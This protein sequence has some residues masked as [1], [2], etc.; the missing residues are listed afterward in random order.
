MLTQS[1]QLFEE[2]CRQHG[3]RY[4]RLPPANHRTPDYV[5]YV[6]RRKIVVEVKEISPNSNE[7]RAHELA[8]QGQ[9]VI[10]SSTPGERVRGKISDAIPQLKSATKGRFPGLLVLLDTGFAADH[11]NSY[12]IM[13]A[14]HGLET[15]YLSVPHAIAEPI[16]LLDKGFGPRRKTT[17]TSN[18]SLS[19]IA[20]F[21]Q[22]DD[23]PSVTVFHNPY[24]RVPLMPCLL[25]R[26]GIKQFG[27]ADKV[28]GSFSK[29]TEL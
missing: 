27:L 19:A 23:P 3:I 21:N 12:N 5:A 22:F 18:T 24:A 8:R 1:E 6:P 17:P 10:T 26:Y 15:H 20:V 13:V 16:T 14:M 28:P 4:K 2:F 25:A 29:W 11:T 7:R 9:F